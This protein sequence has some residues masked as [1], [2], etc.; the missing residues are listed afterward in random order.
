MIYSTFPVGLANAKGCGLAPP[1]CLSAILKNKKLEV[2]QDGSEKI[3]ENGEP[4][5]DAQ[6]LNAK[7]YLRKRNLEEWKYLVRVMDKILFVA[8]LILLT[9]GFIGILMTSG[10]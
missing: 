10:D 8:F 9:G 4:Q 2:Q 5:K 7:L 6:A 3:F 1:A